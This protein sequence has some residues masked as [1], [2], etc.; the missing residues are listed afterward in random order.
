M[1]AILQT[2]YE[3]DGPRIEQADQYARTITDLTSSAARAATQIDK[4]KK[5]LDDLAPIAEAPDVSQRTALDA[6]ANRLQSA[7]SAAVANAAKVAADLKVLRDNPNAP[8]PGVATQP[9]VPAPPARDEQLVQWQTNLDELNARI[10][11]A[12][13]GQSDKSKVATAPARCAL[14]CVQ[15]NHHNRP[16]FRRQG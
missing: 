10:A 7:T 16:S 8:L 2:I 13:A 3:A 9:A 5:Q 14:G 15:P 6:E 12:K 4:I 11:G 1:L